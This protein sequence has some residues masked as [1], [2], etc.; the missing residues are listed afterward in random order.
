MQRREVLFFAIAIVLAG[1]IP[2]T[3]P[4]QLDDTPGPTVMVT[5]HVYDA[6]IFR[7]RYPDG[8][9]VITSEAGAPPSVIFAAPGDDGIL[10]QISAGELN[11]GDFSKPDFIVDVR[12]IDLGEVHITA[13]AAAPADQWGEIRPLFE[14][15]ISS[16]EGD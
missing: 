10:F 11:E 13:L 5:E 16:I 12:G 6:G 9:R 4:P 7:V 14:R 15:V 2:P 8:W 1:C 3:L